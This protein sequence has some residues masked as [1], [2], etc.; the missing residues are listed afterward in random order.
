MSLVPG[1]SYDTAANKQAAETKVTLAMESVNNDLDMRDRNRPATAG[2]D[3]KR[4]KLWYI[5][6]ARTLE[7]GV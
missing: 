7:G 1:T 6:L 4:R 3:K 5:S 2:A